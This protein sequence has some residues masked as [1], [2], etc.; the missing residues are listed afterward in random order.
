M[1]TCSSLFVSPLVNSFVGPCVAPFVNPF[2][3]A[4]LASISATRTLPMQLA[5]RPPRSFTHLSKNRI[6]QFSFKKVM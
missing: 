2:V 1:N 4:S 3:S 6:R 5:A